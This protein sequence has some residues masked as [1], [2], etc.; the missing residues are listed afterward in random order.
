MIQ[1][2]LILAAVVSSL[3]RMLWILSYICLC[4][5]GV[6][7]DGEVAQE[8]AELAA[9]LGSAHHDDTTAYTPTQ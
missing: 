3:P 7:F 1:V 9:P 8:L 5:R 4:I 2:K 6:A